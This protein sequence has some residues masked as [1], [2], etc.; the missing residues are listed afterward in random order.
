MYQL[1]KLRYL[2]QDLEPF[3]DTHTMGLHY[4]KHAKNYLNQLNDLLKK[5]NY[6][7]RYSLEKL[8]YHINEFLE[9]DRENILFNLGGVLNHILY[10][11][12]MNPNPKKPSGKL[13]FYLERFFGSYENFWN[14]FKKKALE[15]K[16]S[17]YT[18]LVLKKNNEL[19]IINVSNQ[20]TPLLYG[21][22]PL[23]NVD[24]WEHAYYIN[25]ENER[26]RY[27]DNF[28]KIADFESANKIFESTIKY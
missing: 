4:E 6:D 8:I 28:E 13:K 10:F 2:Y 26:L 25:Y 11:K 21:Y 20:E 19:E 14:L 23:F 17:G 12:G 24:L 9:V 15:L 18:F 3:I 1:P 5:N 16:G 7:Y 22:I 27:L